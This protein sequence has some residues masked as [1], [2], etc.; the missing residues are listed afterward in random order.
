MPRSSVKKKVVEASKWIA[1]HEAFNSA[2]D[3]YFRKAIMS[4]RKMRQVLTSPETARIAYSN[5]KI[6]EVL[7]QKYKNA[8]KNPEEIKELMEKHLKEGIPIF[9][10]KTLMECDRKNALDLIRRAIQASNAHNETG[11]QEIH[12]KVERWLKHLNF[13]EKKVNSSIDELVSRRSFPNVSKKD[14]KRAKESVRYF[15]EM[16]S[17]Q[18]KSKIRFMSDAIERVEPPAKPNEEFLSQFSAGY[19]PSQVNKNAL[20]GVEGVLRALSE[21]NLKPSPNNKKSR[22]AGA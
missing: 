12:S 19:G 9:E 8:R 22:E 11:L 3:H 18:R 16:D 14:L 13:I 1:L 5:G 2:V 17:E 15:L 10:S 6:R 7:M 4:S 20:K 21:K